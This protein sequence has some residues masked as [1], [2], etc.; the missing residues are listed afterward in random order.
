MLPCTNKNERNAQA[1]QH[2]SST[3]LDA[4]TIAPF[5]LGGFRVDT[6]LLFVAGSTPIV[7]ASPIVGLDAASSTTGSI[8]YRT[9]LNLHRIGH[10]VHHYVGITLVVSYVR[11]GLRGK[12]PGAVKAAG[13]DPRRIFSC[14]FVLFRSDLFFRW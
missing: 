6:F 14:H 5:H 9:A 13:F 10:Q 12:R 11:H 1:I 8:G 4:R 3:T 7:A 2:T